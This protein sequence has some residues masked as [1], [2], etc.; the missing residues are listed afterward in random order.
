M[1]AVRW[2]VAGNVLQRV[3]TVLAMG[4]IARV[5]SEEEYGAYR[6]LIGV[7]T[8]LFVLLPLGFDQLYIREVT[9]RRRMALMLAGALALSTGALALVGVAL[10]WVVARL[11]DFEDWSLMLWLAPLVIA[12][13]SAKLYYKTDLS[14]RLAYR[15]ISIG[16]TLYTAISGGV[17][18]A[19]V[20]AW[21][22][23]YSLYAAFALAEVAELAWLRGHSHLAL[24]RPGKA[25]AALRRLSHPW[26]R[27][28]WLQCSNNGLNTLGSQAP[29]III[30]SSLGKVAAA[31]CSMAN[32]IIMVPVMLLYGALNRVAIA[33]LAGRS[34]EALVGPVLQLLHMCA[35]LIAPVL[36]WFAFMA[37]QVIRVA[38]G[39]RYVDLTT[40]IARWMACYCIFT[41]L[42]SPISL[43]TT[44]LDR[45]DYGV[46]WHVVATTLRIAALAIGMQWGVVAGVAAYSIIS[47]PLWLWWG[48]ML[49]QLMGA[50]QWRFHVAWLRAVP[51]WMA[52]GAMLAA[53]L[54]WSAGWPA[55]VMLT[56]SGAPLL[57]YAGLVRFL[58]PEAWQAAN[59]FAWR[60]RRSPV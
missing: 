49:A 7:H 1:G 24:P 41:V 14:A 36:I 33:A 12:V 54:H 13:Q 47:V 50:G 4:V 37:E 53:V 20:L 3:I 21:P 34:R 40:P 35:V 27:F 8:V 58:Y 25:L 32:W 46:K 11:L 48:S 22:T 15:V 18:L 59:E 30:G 6:Q 44:L 23:A 39:A 56:V 10:H 29:T 57:V 2:V 51:A 5:T 31:A 55:L 19:L 45:P 38:L 9:R 26:R 60:R 52:L 16:E 43:I 17:A 42:F 28:A